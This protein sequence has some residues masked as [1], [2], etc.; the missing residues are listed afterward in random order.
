MMEDRGRVEAGALL[1]YYSDSREAYRRAASYVDRILKGTKPGN[2]PVEQPTR[3]E[4]AINMK[5]AK[6]LGITIPPAVL[7]QA[8]AVIE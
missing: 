6:E 2:L 4:L 5:T 1:A 8:S 3:F 7:L